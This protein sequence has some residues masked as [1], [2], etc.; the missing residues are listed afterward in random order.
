MWRTFSFHYLLTII[1]SGM[2]MILWEVIE[3]SRFELD[4]F[5]IVDV[6]YWP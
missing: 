6:L 1:Y 3:D 5:P 4:R 2:E